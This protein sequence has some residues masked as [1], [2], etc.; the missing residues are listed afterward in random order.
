MH[1]F[2]NVAKKITK[3]M[4]AFFLKLKL[5]PS[6]LKTRNQINIKALKKKLLDYIK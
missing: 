6:C 3:L 4:Q 1:V 2:V 5:N